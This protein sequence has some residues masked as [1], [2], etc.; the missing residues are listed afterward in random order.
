MNEKCSNID[1]ID[2]FKTLE[3]E[4]Q[5]EKLRR[6]RTRRIKQQ[7]LW[8]SMDNEQENI[9]NEYL[10]KTNQTITIEIL[11]LPSIDQIQISDSQIINQDTIKIIKIQNNNSNYLPNGLY[12][13]L[14][15]CIHPLFN[16]RLDYYNLTLGRTLDKNLIKIERFDEQN[17]I[18]LTI[19]NNLFERIENILIHNLF[20]FY[21]NINLRIE[22]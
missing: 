8:F 16:E 11:D 1:Y 22:T 4:R 3:Q 10:L 18:Q 9:P 17:Q 7:H 12:E 20:S 14:L 21:P 6:E 2:Y 13:R 19:N 15:I 5:Y